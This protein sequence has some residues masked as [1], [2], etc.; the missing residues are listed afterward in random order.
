MLKTFSNFINLDP[1]KK[2]FCN[3]LNNILEIGSYE[4]CSEIFFLKKFL[5]QNRLKRLKMTSNEYFENNN[6]KF[7]FNLCRWR[8]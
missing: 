2:W 8:T 1:N 3:N 4:G 7:Y 6:E 5:K